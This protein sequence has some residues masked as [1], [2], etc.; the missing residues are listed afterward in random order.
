MSINRFLAS[1]ALSQ[2]LAGVA[3]PAAAVLQTK[4]RHRTTTE[5]A[6]SGRSASAGRYAPKARQSRGLRRVPSAQSERAPSSDFD[7]QRPVLGGL[8]A[9]VIAGAV[10]VFP[11]TPTSAYQLQRDMCTG[12]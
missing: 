1:A 9:I 7:L 5:A 10:V 4:R 12:A 3:V 6:M 8:A 2:V 11:R